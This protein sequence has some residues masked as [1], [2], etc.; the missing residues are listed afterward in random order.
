MSELTL[1]TWLI[2]GIAAVS[3]AAG[4]WLCYVDDVPRMAAWK[5]WGLALACGASWIVTVPVTLFLSIRDRR[6]GF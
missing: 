6:R 2:Y 1:T 5:R 4:V 3:T